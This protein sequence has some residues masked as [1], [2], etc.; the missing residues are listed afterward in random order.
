[1]R[2][3]KART[4]PFVLKMGFVLLWLT[5]GRLTFSASVTLSWNP[6]SESNLAGYR[7]YYGTSPG[8]HPTSVDAGNQTTFTVSGLGPGTYYFVVLAYNTS[9][10]QSPF[11]NEVSATITGPPLTGLVAAYGFNEGTGTTVNDASGNSN[12]GTVSG[13]TWTTLGRYGRAL[14]FDGVNDWVTV[15]PSGSLNLTTRMT[16]EA[17]VYPTVTPSEWSTV[18]HKEQPGGVVYFLH[19]SS[20]KGDRPATGV[21]IGGEQQ[22]IGGKRLVANSWVHLAGTYDGARLRL[23]VNG[24]QVASRSQ[25][26][27]IQTSASPLR[28]GG[29]SVWGEFFKGT[30][31]EV[32]IYNRA[33]TREEILSDMSTPV[34]LQPPAP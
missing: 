32:R 29:N 20:D 6:N 31:D 9:G 22:L 2:L 26:G 5:F 33:L 16:L 8:I 25:S 21:Y 34:G 28:V 3:S 7:I 1:M 17:W 14:S 10:L 24:S 23:Y 11:S 12:T 27:A 18:I 30:I 13:A 19:A 15:N 4:G